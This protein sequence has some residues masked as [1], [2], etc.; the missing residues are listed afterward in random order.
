MGTKLE[1]EVDV[2][3]FLPKMYHVLLLNDNY[4]TFDFVIEVL[5]EI[6]KKVEEEAINITIK[7]D[8]GGSAIVGTYTKEIAEAKVAQVRRKAKESSY[9]LR[10]VMQE[11]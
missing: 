10:A 9:P 2:D 11:A 4:S 8:K 6:F 1:E 7:V 5:K 3:L